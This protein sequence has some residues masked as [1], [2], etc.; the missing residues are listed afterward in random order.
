M[1]FTVISQ[2]DPSIYT[3]VSI[4]RNSSD[5]IV[6]W[7]I[8]NVSRLR[9]GAIDMGIAYETHSQTIRT[10]V[11]PFEIQAAPVWIV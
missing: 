4:Q 10:T 5:A 3:R 7:T 11:A 2:Y 9:S 1:I 8:E 6:N